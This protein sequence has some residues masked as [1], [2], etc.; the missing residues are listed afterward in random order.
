[1]SRKWLPVVIIALGAITA[2]WVGWTWLFVHLSQETGTSNSASRA[3]DFWSGFGSDLGELT[4][5]GAVV[6]SA[7]GFYRSHQC[8]NANCWIGPSW[9][10]RFGSNVTKNGH[11]LCK[12]CIT[13]P[14]I[15]LDIH[16]IHEDHK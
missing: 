2:V 14:N 13:L 16:P 1:M 7:Y 5:V 12:V 3:Y 6:G 10:R 11:K 9:F 4:L 15:E 8:Q